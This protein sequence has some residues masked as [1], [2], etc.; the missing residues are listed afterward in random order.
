MV[1]QF[2]HMK[3]DKQPKTPKWDVT[4]L[5]FQELKEVLSKWQ[6]GLEGTGWNSLFWN[7]HDLPRIVSRWGN[8]GKYRVESAKMLAMVLHGMKGTPYIYQGEEIGMTNIALSNIKDYRDIETLNMYKERLEEG[9]TQE[10]IMH[11]IH[12]M[13]RDN[14]RTPM[15]W[16]DCEYAGFSKHEPWLCVNPNFHE[17][18]VDQA[19]KD[20][21]SIFY[22]YQRLI[23]MRK[24]MEIFS[25]GDYHLLDTSDQIFAYERNWNNQK[26][27]VIA[28]FFE[29]P[30]AFPDIDIEGMQVLL[31]NYEA[32]DGKQLRAYEAMILFKG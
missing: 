20:K 24:E 16:S 25:Q 18:N 22:T 1:F 8:D 5:R 30:C 29:K 10:E 27:V 21:H 19:L 14:A 4:G 7:N 28:N 12:L 2:E 13:G 9:Y 3:L 17:I 32:I 15:Q 23:Q 6:Y 11:S 31:H 26:L